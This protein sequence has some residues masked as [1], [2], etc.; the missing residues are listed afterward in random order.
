MHYIQIWDSCL[1][2][3]GWQSLYDGEWRD[4]T[5]EDHDEFKINKHND[6]ETK[7]K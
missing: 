2:V 3:E 6:T 1:H 7:K 5:G 4:S